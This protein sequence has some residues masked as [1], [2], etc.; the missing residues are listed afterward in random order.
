MRLHFF[1][2]VRH[3]TNIFEKEDM[4]FYIPNLCPLSKEILTH[5][6]FAFY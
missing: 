4:V 1:Q 5:Y 3:R 6:L 2:F